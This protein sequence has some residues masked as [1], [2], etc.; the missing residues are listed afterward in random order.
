MLN[1]LSMFHMD[2]T[3]LKTVLDPTHAHKFIDM[4]VKLLVN[5]HPM[6]LFALQNRGDEVLEDGAYWAVTGWKENMRG[7]YLTM[8]E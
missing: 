5:G 8:K 4:R 1:N 2:M 6:T 3:S 7:L